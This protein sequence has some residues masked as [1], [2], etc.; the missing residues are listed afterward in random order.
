MGPGWQHTDEEED[1]D[2]KN[3]GSKHRYLRLMFAVAAEAIDDRN[4][5]DALS[6]PAAASVCSWHRDGFPA[7]AGQQAAAP[8]GTSGGLPFSPPSRRLGMG[9]GDESS[10]A[11]PMAAPPAL[12]QKRAPTESSRP[13]PWFFRLSVTE[14]SLLPLL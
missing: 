9:A 6:R 3:D 11:T 2:D 14:T 7:G 8:D 4:I 1:E 10:G 5:A 13:K 12:A